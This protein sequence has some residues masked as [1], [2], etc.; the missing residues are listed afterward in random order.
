MVS[1]HFYD[2]EQVSPYPDLAAV[3]NIYIVFKMAA[4]RGVF[5]NVIRQIGIALSTWIEVALNLRVRIWHYSMQSRF[6]VSH[7]RTLNVTPPF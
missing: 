7:L 2:L 5:F 4:L 6:G 3:N 1:S